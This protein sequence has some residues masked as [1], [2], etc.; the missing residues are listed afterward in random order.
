MEATAC[1]HQV[2]MPDL[3]DF[4]TTKE[5]AELLG[6]GRQR[7]YDLIHDERLEAIKIGRDWLVS[8]ESIE[9]FERA[10]PW[11]LTKPHDE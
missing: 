2:T 5:A 11:D 3:E 6:V 7:I 8:R 4:V 9:N 1:Y 10:Q